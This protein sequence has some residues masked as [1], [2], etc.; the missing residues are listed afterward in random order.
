MNPPPFLLM[1]VLLNLPDRERESA[2]VHIAFG[3]VRLI[4]N[5]I[6]LLQTVDTPTII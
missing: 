1:A 2:E 6:E 5:K 3:L 4:I